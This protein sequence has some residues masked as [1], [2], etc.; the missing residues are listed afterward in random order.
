MK[1]NFAFLLFIPFLDD[2]GTHHIGTTFYAR[3]VKADIS[4]FMRWIKRKIG[5]KFNDDFIEVKLY[6]KS[7]M[8][9]FKLL[10][11][12]KKRKKT[13]DDDEPGNTG[14]NE[15]GIY[16]GL[17]WVLLCLG[18]AMKFDEETIA[19]TLYSFL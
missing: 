10:K 6:H 11:K 9:I 13:N 14:F 4:M 15:A 7:Q 2:Q 19:S 17:T 5:E 8:K 12:K 3:D 1:F 16:N 18:T